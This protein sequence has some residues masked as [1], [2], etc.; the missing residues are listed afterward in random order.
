MQYDIPPSVAVSVGVN[1][2]QMAFV[3]KA[4]IEAARQSGLPPLEQIDF[5]NL[6][7]RLPINLEEL[8]KLLDV[9][10]HQESPSFRIRWIGKDPSPKDGTLEIQDWEFKKL[11][12][13]T[14][15]YFLND[16]EKEELKRRQIYYQLNGG[17][18]GSNLDIFATDIIIVNLNFVYDKNQ[19]NRAT[20]EAAFQKQISF[21][22]RV[23]GVIE[24]KF[25]TI[26]T[27]GVGNAATGTIT[28]GRRNDFV[29]VFLS[30]GEQ[31]SGVS[32]VDTINDERTGEAVT[33]DTFLTKGKLEG[34]GGLSN[35]S[36]R[37]EA[38]AHELGH[39]FGIT[40][41]PNDKLFGYEELGGFKIRNWVSDIEINSA[42]RC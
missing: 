35:Y 19:Y 18:L 30:I 26:W 8:N 14:F 16:V 2:T 33:R 40:G 13:K 22:E 1:D 32:F 9:T 3:R 24:I 39:K 42:L 6:L 11:R 4:L 17:V 37:E 5:A 25:Y 21:A 29:N 27:A 7:L 34:G 10:K 36:L 41:D 20:A 28:E 15:T 31:D 23:Y 38:L 12:G